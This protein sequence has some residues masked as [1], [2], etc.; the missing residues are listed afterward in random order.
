M[1]DTPFYFRFYIYVQIFI[2][3]EQIIKIFFGRPVPLS[4]IVMLV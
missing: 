2:T 3:I 1:T 4:E